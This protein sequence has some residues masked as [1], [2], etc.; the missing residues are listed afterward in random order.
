MISS[1]YSRCVTTNIMHRCSVY[2]H[3][4]FFCRQSSETREM[5]VETLMDISSYYHKSVYET[6]NV[7][8]IYLAEVQHF[9][10]EGLATTV[11]KRTIG[12]NAISPVLDLNFVQI[13]IEIS[14]E[15]IKTHSVRYSKYC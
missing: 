9:P 12:A 15:S 5:N 14:S 3:R 1:E 8:D 6:L 13:F 2:E 4:S 11:S 10:H 7:S